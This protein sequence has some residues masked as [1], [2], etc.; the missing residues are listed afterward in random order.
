[1]LPIAWV[2]EMAPSNYRFGPYEVDVPAHE[3]RKHGLR[4][5]LREKPFEI[6]VCLLEHPDEVVTREY[7]QS[8]LWPEGVFVNF[9]D[10]LNTA[11]NRLRNALGEGARGRKYIKTL[12]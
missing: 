6:L 10:S 1:M 8:R 7:L 9:D 3:L 11:V 12:P 2:A 4:I 5:R